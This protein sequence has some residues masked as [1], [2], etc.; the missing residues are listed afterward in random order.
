MELAY[1][2]DDWWRSPS[3]IGCQCQSFGF[4]EVH[5]HVRSYPSFSHG[6]ERRGV[7]AGRGMNLRRCRC[8]VA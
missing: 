2:D 3:P 6:M 1:L 4:R 8:A 7:S 5:V